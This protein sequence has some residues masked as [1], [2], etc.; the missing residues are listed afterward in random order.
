M[1]AV[2]VVIGLII[3]AMVGVAL[4]PMLVLL[5]LAGGGDGWGLCNG[6]LTSCRAAYFEGPELLAA[7]VVVLFLLL[8]LLRLALY[9]RRVLEE[10]QEREGSVG[11]GE[12]F[13]GG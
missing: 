12:R 2:R 1:I 13:G 7:L 3:G 11:G 5:D 8:M 4:M 6:G 9:A 10:R